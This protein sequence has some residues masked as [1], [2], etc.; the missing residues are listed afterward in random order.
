[1]AK[2]A[3]QIQIR[4]QLRHL[5]VFLLFLALM[6]FSADFFALPQAVRRFSRHTRRSPL[7]LSTALLFFRMAVRMRVRMSVL[8]S[9]AEDT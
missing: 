3:K 5:G 6:V 7:G 4:R 1:M 9:S 8:S 2:I